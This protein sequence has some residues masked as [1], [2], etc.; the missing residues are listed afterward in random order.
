MNLPYNIDYVAPFYDDSASSTG[1]TPARRLNNG[2]PYS[3]TDMNKYLLT[4]D[5]PFEASGQYSDMLKT[6]IRECLQYH[7]RFRP[8][9][10]DL[11]MTTERYR[12]EYMEED[13]A[14]DD[15]ID[16]EEDEASEDLIVK[17]EG[18]MNNFKV[19]G[20]YPPPGEQQ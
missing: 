19:G 8:K 1:K 3:L 4:G 16:E 12:R 13:K 20:R 2:K 6:T 18:T 17:V 9:I 7:P 10:E 11:K 5:T 14:S 15:L